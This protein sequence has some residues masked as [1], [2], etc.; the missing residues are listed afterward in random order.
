M[1]AD[2]RRRPA[3]LEHGRAPLVLCNGVGASLEVF[4]PLVDKLDRATTV[5]R[6]DVPG[7][8]GSPNSP[9]PYGFPYLAMVLGRVLRRLGLNNRVD[10]LGV[11]LGWRAWPSSSHFRTH[12]GAGG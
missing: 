12:E 1:P 7:A 10:V 9:F 3:R 5:V 2:P 8:G 6:F 4:D 11:V